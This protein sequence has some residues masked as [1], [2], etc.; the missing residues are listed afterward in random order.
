MI[1]TCVLSLK[2]V[3]WIQTVGNGDSTI[4]SIGQSLLMLSGPVEDSNL[5]LSKVGSAYS[6]RISLKSGSKSGMADT[7]TAML[8]WR[9]VRL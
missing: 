2:P 5:Q 1:D 9:L 7:A 4:T 8:R 3:S 6:L